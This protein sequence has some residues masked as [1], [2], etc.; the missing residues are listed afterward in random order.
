ML[1]M[2][3]DMPPPKLCPLTE[4]FRVVPA[5]VIGGMVPAVYALAPTNDIAGECEGGTW[6]LGFAKPGWLCLAARA[7][8]TIGNIGISAPLR[9]CLDDGSHPACLVADMP[10]CT[11]GLD[12]NG[13]QISCTISA[14]QT[15]PPNMIWQQQ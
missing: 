15:Y 2:D 9:V 4:M 6:G 10:T 3:G 8:D 1:G 14:A 11:N 5:R 13:K 12:D 7:E